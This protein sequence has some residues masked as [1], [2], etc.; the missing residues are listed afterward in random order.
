MSE[1]AGLMVLISNYELTNVQDSESEFEVTTG[2]V[3]QP[4]EAI[5]LHEL[6]WE[7]RDE[8]RFVFVKAQSE[9]SNDDVPDPPEDVA[10]DP[11]SEE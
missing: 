8:N 11:I 9:A 1:A 2:A 6:G 3:V 7:K 5:K 4:T 10:P